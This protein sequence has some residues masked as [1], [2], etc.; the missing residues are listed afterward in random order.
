MKVL[1]INEGYSDNLGDQAINDSLQYLLNINGIKD[2][3]FQDFTKNI[4][5]P[6]PIKL[7]EVQ[8]AKF[9]IKSIMKYLIP[10]KI[11]WLLKNLRR[12]IKASKNNYDLVIIGGGQLIMGN[13][14]FPIAM[15][16]WIN[17]LKFF[18]NSNI[19]I[20]SVGIAS[21]IKLSIFNKLLFNYSLSKVKKIYLRDNKSIELSQNIF[22]L[23]SSFIYDVAFIHNQIKDKDIENKK[24]YILLGVMPLKTYN[25]HNIYKLS[26]YEYYKTWID[27]L[28]KNHIKVEQVSLFYTT[29]DDRIASLDF[30]QYVK[31]KF[32]ITLELIETNTKN[33]L[34]ETYKNS[35]LIISARMHAL[36]LGLSY[37]CKILT[38]PI[39]EKLIEFNN[40]YIEKDFNI[41]FIQQELLLSIKH[42][43]K[44]N[45]NDTNKFK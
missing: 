39:S 45:N 40:L 30:Q 9:R 2:I 18:G 16:S 10:V 22:K 42:L 28:N 35:S 7:N 36:I 20:Y 32:N 27:F 34:I 41:N 21:D 12:I 3:D 31:N 15:F 29:H 1:V 17:I 6:I 26:K 44:E 14:S 4:D 19:I 37:N 24:H 38:Y 13:V 11:R 43:I 23:S 33:K 8:N 5:K 25:E